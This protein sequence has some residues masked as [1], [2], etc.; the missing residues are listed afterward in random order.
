MIQ[1]LLVRCTAGLV[2]DGVRHQQRLDYIPFTSI[3]KIIKNIETQQKIRYPACV[4]LLSGGRAN[5]RGGISYPFIIYLNSKAFILSAATT[6]GS[7]LQGGT[8]GNA[9]KINF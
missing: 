4:C 3:P 9:T 8:R 6:S 5:K 1:D 7:Q 2:C